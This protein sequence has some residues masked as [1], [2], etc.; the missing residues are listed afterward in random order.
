MVSGIAD[1]WGLLLF[2]EKLEGLDVG[3]S[4]NNL[5]QLI[6]S[7]FNGWGGVPSSVTFSQ[8]DL[9]VVL[10]LICCISLFFLM[11]RFIYGIFVF[12]GRGR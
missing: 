11:F 5:W 1:L 12:W 3:Q 2:G 8:S 10:S 4:L 7:I 9:C 6:L